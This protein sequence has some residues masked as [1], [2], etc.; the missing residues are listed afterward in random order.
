MSK[1]LTI[2]PGDN[3]SVYKAKLEFIIHD[4]VKALMPVADSFFSITI[5]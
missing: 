2:N 3:V 4:K 5:T 1:T